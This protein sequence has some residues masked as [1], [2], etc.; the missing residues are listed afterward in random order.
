MC[1]AALKHDVNKIM[2]SS[3]AIYGFTQADTGESGEQNYFNDYGRT[4]YL[5]E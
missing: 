4:K 5:A 1:E 3:V 2:K